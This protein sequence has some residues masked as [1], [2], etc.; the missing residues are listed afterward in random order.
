[1]KREDSDPLCSV[2]GVW[3]GQISDDTDVYAWAL[4]NARAV[5]RFNPRVTA[6]VEFMGMVANQKVC[7]C[8][9]DGLR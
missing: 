4:E 5:R 3:Q 6:S 1:M 7:V 8:G 2:A 9:L